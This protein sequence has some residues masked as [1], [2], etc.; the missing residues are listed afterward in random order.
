VQVNNDDT[1]YSRI[2][3][4]SG[5]DEQ[6]YNRL[7]NIS[8]TQVSFQPINYHPLVDDGAMLIKKLLAT[9]RVTRKSDEQKYF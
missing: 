3:D 7:H 5:N 2:T 1:A 9:N 8:Y 4:H 6:G